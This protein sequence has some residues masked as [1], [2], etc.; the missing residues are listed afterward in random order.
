[1][2][3]RA[4]SA[5]WL[6]AI[7][8]GLGA[9]GGGGD[10]PTVAELPAQAQSKS[11]LFPTDG[12]MKY[13][14]GYDSVTG[15]VHTTPCMKPVADIIKDVSADPYSNVFDYKMK[16][17][18]TKSELYDFLQASYQT[19]VKYVVGKS[20]MAVEMA[21]QF[22]HESESIY[23]VVKSTWDG[24]IFSARNPVFAQTDKAAFLADY[25]TYLDFVN[26]CGD[27]FALSLQSGMHFYAMFKFTFSSTSERNQVRAKLYSKTPVVRTTKEFNNEMGF[28]TSTSSVEVTARIVGGTTDALDI[29]TVRTVDNFFG[30]V[31]KYADSEK[32]AIIAGKADGLQEP[33]PGLA[34]GYA[35]HA[36]VVPYKTNLTNQYHLGQDWFS[37]APSGVWSDLELLAKLY[38]AQIDAVNQLDYMVRNPALFSSTEVPGKS[39]TNNE[40]HTL[41]QQRDRFKASASPDDS[42][43]GLQA[44]MQLC[45]NPD[46]MLSLRTAGIDYS[47]VSAGF[48]GK[49]RKYC[50]GLYPNDP[51]GAGDCDGLNMCI[52]IYDKL[53]QTKERD[54]LPFFT[55][56]TVLSKGLDVP[57]AIV[58][59]NQK[60]LVTLPLLMT[61]VP[62]DC[63][64][65]KNA[66]PN[67]LADGD[68]TVYFMGKADKPYTVYCKDLA[69]ASPKTYLTLNE[70]YVNERI[71]NNVQTPVYNFSVSAWGDSKYQIWT[72]Q[73]YQLVS[74]PDGVAINATNRDFAW[75]YRSSIEATDA[76]N[77]NVFNGFTQAT[78]LK[79]VNLDLTRT[80]LALRQDNLLEV[81]GWGWNSDKPYLQFHSYTDD[82]KRVYIEGMTAAIRQGGHSIAVRNVEAANYI[83]LE[84][85]PALDATNR[86]DGANSGNKTVAVPPGRDAGTWCA[87]SSD[88]WCAPPFLTSINDLFTMK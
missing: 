1:M 38:T 16:M 31:A 21:N 18:E 36:V 59:A 70:A 28:D 71:V 41:A 53:S 79:H 49:G 24:P 9:C 33:D 42:S 12:T 11:M 73:K 3:E 22:K 68:Y 23:V 4:R 32:A 72:W 65:L 25:P 48:N 37:N 30:F 29:T 86:G 62:Q 40:I 45:S 88:A 15:T 76:S 56:D 17:V 26:D 66:S 44:L 52:A 61:S 27:T 81:S 46:D 14:S 78:V 19:E 51:A 64:A 10:S 63:A 74:T 80:G 8:M 50:R 47:D 60:P 69:T 5:A 39:L 2:M 77:S 85:V 84:Y 13:L 35:V 55:F 67:A 83:W 7:C 87:G 82:A 34:Y 43:R 58:D 57:D 6:A 20:Q 75:V 54:R